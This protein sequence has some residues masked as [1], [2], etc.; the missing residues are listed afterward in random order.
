L[1]V[2]VSGS[3]MRAILQREFA[4]FVSNASVD[5]SRVVGALEHIM[6]HGTLTI[7]GW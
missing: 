7:T 6:G 5:W 4:V 2:K 1:R 3:S